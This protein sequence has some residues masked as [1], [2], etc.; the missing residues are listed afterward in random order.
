MAIGHCHH[1]IVASLLKSDEGGLMWNTSTPIFPNVFNISSL[2]ETS[3]LLLKSNSP[4]HTLKCSILLNESFKEK[5]LPLIFNCSSPVNHI[6]AMFF[7]SHDRVLKEAILIQLSLPLKICK[8]GS[9]FSLCLQKNPNFQATVNLPSLK[10]NLSWQQEENVRLAV[11][12]GCPSISVFER[13]PQYQCF[14]IHAITYYSRTIGVF[15]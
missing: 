1:F 8:N 5:V 14:Q 15:R 12:S 3:K 10:S 13:H 7:S 2:L 6:V 9:T 11:Q 4:W